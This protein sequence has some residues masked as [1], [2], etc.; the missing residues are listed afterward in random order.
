MAEQQGDGMIDMNELQG[1][2]D[3]AIEA[4]SDLDTALRNIEKFIGQGDID[5]LDD[6]I[7]TC[8]A[9]SLMEH[10]QEQKPKGR[11]RKA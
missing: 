4:R 6:I 5:G 10:V 8:D 11:G 1:L 3:T 9:E 2:I 7:D